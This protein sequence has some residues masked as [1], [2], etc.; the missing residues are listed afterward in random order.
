[1]S[2]EASPPIALLV[3]CYNAAAHLPRLWATVRAQTLP[4]AE[5][6]VYDDASTDNTASIARD[7]GA[8]VITG[9]SNVGS[10]AGR[11]QLLAASRCP[12]VH[13][14]DADDILHPD[15]VALMGARAA[16]DDADVVLCQVDWQDEQTKEVVQRWRY[17]EAVYQDERA[18]ADMLVNIIGGIGGIYRADALRAAG[19]FRP[20]LRYWEDMDLHL[21]LWRH[22]ARIRVVDTV[23]SLAYRRS[24]STSNSNLAAVWRAKTDLLS[25]WL[26]DP[27]L[28]RP[29]TDDLGREAENI[30][31]RQLALGD[32]GGAR[33]SFALARRTGREVPSTRSRALR[34]LHALFGGWVATRLQF[35]LRRLAHQPPSTLR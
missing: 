4:F 6:I 33:V 32:S 25:E 35:H 8:R 5:C 14:H 18:P 2:I 3:P 27:V 1:M 24:D 15:F 23:L 16:R 34:L 30:L 29:L 26:A 12:W 19:G 21:R 22:G 28:G 13:F 10:G 31:Y 20:A 11:N 9:E 7:L 17:D